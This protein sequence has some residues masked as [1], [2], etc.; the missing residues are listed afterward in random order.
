MGFITHASEYAGK[1]NMDYVLRPA[2]SGK[3][4]QDQGFRVVDTQGA[5]SVK[6]TFFDKLNHI[7]LPYATGFG[8]K[9][10]FT[11]KQKKFEV[12]EFKA[13]T[14]YSK[15]DYKATIQEQ[16]IRKN[17][18][19]DNDIT[20]SALE[21]AQLEVLM[22]GVVSDVLANFWLGDKSKTH[23]KAGT[24]PD[25]TTFA[26]G[27]ADKYYNNINGVLKNII[28][29]IYQHYVSKQNEI[30]G[31]NL[32]TYPTLYLT[33]S[34]GTVYAYPSAATRTGAQS[35]DRLFSFTATNATYPY[36]ALITA[37]NASGFGGY[38]TLQQA[39]T[40]G[41]FE[42]HAQE[43]DYVHRSLLPAALTTDTA[44]TYFKKVLRI[45]SQELLSLKDNGG[46][47]FYVTNSI[48]QN[49]EDTLLSGTTEIARM[50]KVNGTD[51]YAYSGIPI[52]PMDVDGQIESDFASAFPHNW[53]VLTS[54]AN[55][56]LV[57]NGS[58]EFAETRLWFNPDQNENRQ[59]TQFEFGANYILPELISVAYYSA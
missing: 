5:G 57:I 9:Y 32:A 55:L 39:C 42:L 52:I 33:E 38:V 19:G 37:L 18:Y 51:R 49:Y 14:A 36:R 44:E 34:G 7:L 4:V 29:D 31:W 40:S 59:R 25:G 26:A 10:V 35:G 8:G 43:W 45:A 30:T 48:L 6:L 20:A 21:K 53:I 28:T 24:Y 58:S 47:V 54:P 50:A 13:E 46:L 11:K 23:T 3:K 16:L 17:N 2:F 12:Q 15:Q 41:V 22:N 27:D 56:A 1:E